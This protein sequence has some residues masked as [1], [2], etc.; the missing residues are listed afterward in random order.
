[1]TTASR[2]LWPLALLVCLLVAATLCVRAD[3][4]EEL[5]RADIV[6]TTK[7][8]MTKALAQYGAFP[9]QATGKHSKNAYVIIHYEGTPKV[10]F[11]LRAP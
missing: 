4:D 3:D 5:S 11:F 9:A 6:Q 2:R 8:D 10:R 7:Y 1:M